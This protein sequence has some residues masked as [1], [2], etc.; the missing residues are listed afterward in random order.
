M[1]ILDGGIK[2]C[3]KIY[4]V[5]KRSI[6]YNLYWLVT[7]TGKIGEFGVERKMRFFQ[8][9]VHIFFYRKWGFKRKYLA[10]STKVLMRYGANCGN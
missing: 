5:A 2:L 4:L 3:W 6:S 7:P 1:G 9:G 8:L 10:L